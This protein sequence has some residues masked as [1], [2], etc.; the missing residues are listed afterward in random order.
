MSIKYTQ[1]EIE[2][3]TNTL[4]NQVYL[5]KLERTEISQQINLLKKQIENLANQDLQQTK[6]L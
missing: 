3:K 4:E 1:E 2:E 5:L 6:L